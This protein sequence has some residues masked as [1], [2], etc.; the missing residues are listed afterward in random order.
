MEGGSKMTQEEKA[1]RYNEALEIAKKNYVT[2]QD[3]CEGSQIGVECFKN[4]LENIFP[5]L[6]ESE[7]EKIEKAIFGMV[8]DSDNELWSSY[9]VSKSDVLAWLEKQGKQN[10][11]IVNFKASDWY[12]SKVDGKIYNAKF[13]EEPHTNQKRRLEIEKA[14]F[15]ATGI[16]EQEEW[17]IKG[18]EW[19]DKHPK[20]GLVNIEKACEWLDNNAEDYTIDG[21]L[22]IE[23]LI[24]SFEKAMEK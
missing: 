2:A 4:T 20:K 5:E 22:S 17:F 11:K 10:E 6:K 24:Y 16:I 23:N 9:D 12:V 21:G 7:D 1:K 14:A 3:L 18:A 8:Y 19:S 15:S 13:M